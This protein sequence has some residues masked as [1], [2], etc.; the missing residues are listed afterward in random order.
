MTLLLATTAYLVLSVLFAL[1]VG[2]VI[3]MGK[4]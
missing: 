3:R 4:R 2:R 1:L